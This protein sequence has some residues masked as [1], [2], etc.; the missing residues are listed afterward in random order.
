MRKRKKR[1]WRGRNEAIPRLLATNWLSPVGQ[2]RVLAETALV[3][4]RDAE[5]IGRFGRLRLHVLGIEVRILTSLRTPSLTDRIFIVNVH[6]SA[7]LSVKVKSKSI[8]RQS[9]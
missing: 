4:T 2:I 3:L 1:Y 5:D 7:C 8:A 6:L 9:Q